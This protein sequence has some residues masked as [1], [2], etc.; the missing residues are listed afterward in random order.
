MKDL[1][2]YTSILLIF[3]LASCGGGDSAPPAEEAQ[4]PA[5]AEEGMA[6][7]AMDL[8]EGVTAAMVAE[9]ETVFT[10]AGICFT[11][12][13]EGGV[14]GPLAPDLTDDVWLN[15]DGSYESIVQNIMTG[16][17]EPV[18][19]PGLMLPKGGAPITDEQ[20]NAVAAYVWTLSNGS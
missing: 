17:P 19:H 13:L 15:I 9:G 10:G 1:M 4:E 14:G 8:P 2:R 6:A 16:V 11:C 3:V 12:H 5:P 7:P 20:V 18:E